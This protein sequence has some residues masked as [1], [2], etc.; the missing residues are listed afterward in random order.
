MVRSTRNDCDD[1]ATNGASASAVSAAEANR[2]AGR[3]AIIRSTASTSPPGTSGQS[4]SSGVG[5]WRLVRLALLAQRRGREWHASRQQVIQRATQAVDVGPVIDCVGVAELL[6]SGIVR[7]AQADALA[8]GSTVAELILKKTRQAEVEQFHLPAG[9]DEQV[10]R[11]DVAM[12]QSALVSVVQSQGY[13]VD[14]VR[15]LGRRKSALPEHS[16]QAPPLDMLHH[17]EMPPVLLAAVKGLDD[18]RV[19]R[20]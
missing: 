13:L 1:P 19:R 3:L 16:R 7:G 8:S 2:S 18:S 6:R 12:N 17:Q 4:S 20:N 9:C 10:A 15:C 14:V 11:F 5:V